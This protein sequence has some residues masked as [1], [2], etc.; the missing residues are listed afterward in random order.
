MYFEIA[1]QWALDCKH[2]ILY[3]EIDK[4]RM[5]YY[6]VSS[7]AHIT[8]QLAEKFNELVDYF[9]LVDSNITDV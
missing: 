9:F 5:F 1:N 3:Y 4:F 2:N 6:L 7:N 8:T